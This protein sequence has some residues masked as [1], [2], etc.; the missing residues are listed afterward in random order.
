[1]TIFPQLK[2]AYSINLQVVGEDEVECC[3]KLYDANAPQS[4]LMVGTDQG[5]VNIYLNGFLLC[6]HVYVN[7]MSG[8]AIKTSK[9]K[10]IPS[11]VVLDIAVA[12]N[13]SSFSVICKDMARRPIRKNVNVSL[14]QKFYSPLYR[15]TPSSK[16]SPFPC[17]SFR[18]ALR[19][20]RKCPRCTA[21]CAASQTTSQVADWRHNKSDK[22]DSVEVG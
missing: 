17:P 5:E 1:M 6:G 8:I 16:S 9:P 14:R 3:Q 22:S 4:L 18:L 10:P 19:N 2:K 15:T 21:S 20:W 11:I 13:L 12:P 7:V